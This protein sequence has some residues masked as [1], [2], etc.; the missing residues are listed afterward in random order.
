MLTEL[1][2]YLPNK[3]G[4]LNAVLTELSMANVNVL[5]LSIDQAGVYSAVRIICDDVRKAKTKL[6]GPRYFYSETKVFAIPL[7]HH[8]GELKK[9]TQLL[10]DN[11]INIEYGYLGWSPGLQN[12]IVL[13]KTNNVNRA[14]KIL[15]ASDYE[16]LT[17]IPQVLP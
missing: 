3:A 15:R 2:L 5:A 4:Q 12:A 14:R 16:D 13:L 6:K 1:S 10:S 7:P 11:G 8:A 17:N 9:V